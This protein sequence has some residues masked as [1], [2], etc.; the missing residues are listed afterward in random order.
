M[1][2]NFR[3]LVGLLSLGIFANAQDDTTRVRNLEVYGFVMTDM[4]YNVNQINPTYFDALR[5]TRLPTYSNQFAPDG[6]VFFSVRQTR[7]GVRGWTQTPVGE[8]KTVFEFDLFG[9]GV[10]EG[11]TTIRPRH[12][13]GE[14]GR[15]LVGQTNSPF[16]DGDVFPNTLEY[17]GPTGMV[18]FRNI[19]IRYALLQGDNE[20]FVALE[21]P[22]ASA[23]EGTFSDR[24]ELDSVVGQ[25]NL[26]DL[27]AHFKK[28]GKWGHI[29][30]GGMLRSM[31]WKDVHTT[32]GYNISGSAVG[33]GLNLSTNI[34][35]GKMDV[36]RGSVIYGEGVENYMNDAPTDVG[37]LDHPGDPQKPFTGKALPVTGIV[38]FL[39]HNWTDKLSTSIGYSSTYIDNT[40]DASPTAY[41]MGQYAIINLLAA[42]F[43][44]AMMG[45]EVQWGQ[46]EGFNGFTSSTTKI[47]FSFKYNFSQVFYRKKS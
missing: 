35:I 39:D 9:V 30:L 46:R 34:N 10:D 1:K 29:Q 40:A 3:L 32:G 19:Q 6:T 16:M 2:L 17:W 43:K 7:L 24:S 28:S 13:Y 31:K 22:G 5:V 11:Q 14:I 4:G 47:Q 18:F 37:L 8:L 38:A 42:P 20:L 25:F 23:D 44:N 41:K 15:F 21:R 33:W 36:F 45:A 27:S 26:P 12:I